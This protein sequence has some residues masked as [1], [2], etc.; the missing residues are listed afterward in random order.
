M[1]SADTFSESIA[2]TPFLHLN[3]KRLSVFHNIFCFDSIKKKSLS[4]AFLIY[5]F[6]YFNVFL[7]IKTNKKY[8]YYLY[9][10]A[11]NNYLFRKATSKFFRL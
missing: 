8:T 11:K 9:E 10:K 6:Y 1:V 5:F 7:N 3:K 4:T 2:V